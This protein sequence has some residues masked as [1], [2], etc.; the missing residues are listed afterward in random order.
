MKETLR[1]F[2]PDDN[3]S[4]ENISQSGASG[5]VSALDHIKTGDV[6]TLEEILKRKKIIE[7]SGLEWSVIE[8][9]PVHNDIKTWSGDYYKYV[10]NYKKSIENVGKAGLKLVCYNFMAVV[11]WTRTNLRYK[12]SNKSLALRFDMADFA[13]YDIFIL[14]RKNAKNDYTDKVFNSAERNFKIFSKD[15]INI[16]EKNIIAGLPGGE[17]S[18]SRKQILNEIENF[19]MIGTEGYRK[20]LFKFL[21]E[22][23]PIAERSQVKMCIHPDDPPF[24]LFGLPR[25]V[26]SADDARKLLNAYPSIYNGLTMCVGSYGAGF[27]NDTPKLVKEFKSHIHFAHLRNIIKEPDGSFYESDHLDGDNDMHAIA[28]QLLNE[29][30]YRQEYG[31]KSIIPMRPDHGHLIGNEI[32]EDNVNPGYSFVGRLRGL[33]ELRG[34]IFGIEKSDN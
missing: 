24:P 5:V 34:L 8:S 17:G 9:I 15:E 22:I 26:S 6:W 10:N 1:W 16:L 12:L 11:D 32:N 31:D 23:I 21:K 29:E 33:S 14:N 13:L 18:Y 19:S 25:V 20:N 30:K 2:G 28:K 27:Q 3:I 7:S 4:L